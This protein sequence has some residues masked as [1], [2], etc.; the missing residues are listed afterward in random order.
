MNLKPAWST[1]RFSGQPGLQIEILFSK[2]GGSGRVD[3]GKELNPEVKQLNY[4][5]LLFNYDSLSK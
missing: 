1:Q 4:M 5:L 3:V 2:E